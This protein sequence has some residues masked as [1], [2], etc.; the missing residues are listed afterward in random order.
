M[1]VTAWNARGVEI[2]TVWSEHKTSTGF[3]GD[4][5]LGYPEAAGSS[6]PWVALVPT[7]RPV[8]P[9]ANWRR[10][11][12]SEVAQRASEIAQASAGVADWRR[13]AHH[14][15]VPARLRVFDEFL[16]YLERSNVEVSVQTPIDDLTVMAYRNMR[17]ART[18]VEQ[19]FRTAHQRLAQELIHG[20]DVEERGQARR[21]LVG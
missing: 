6:N 18:Q 9:Q 3:H 2:G 5:L 10:V 16:T 21:Q 8:P 15:D 11:T 20:R 19:L 1:R 7:S 14:P 12:W 4:Q 13:R 17:Q